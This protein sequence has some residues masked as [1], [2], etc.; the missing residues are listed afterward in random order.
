[1]SKHF[2][3]WKIDQPQLLPPSVQ[4]FVP[5]GHLSRFIVA[6]V[7]ESLDL[8]AIIGSYTSGLGQPP[9]DPRMM[10]ALLLNGYASGVYSSRRIA[11]AAIERADFMMIVAL[12]P[13]DFRTI[14]DFRKRHLTALAGLF[15]QVLKLAE[16]AGLV[17]LGHVALDGTKIKANASKHKAMSYERMK[18]REAELQA[19]VDRWL[20]AAEAA[21]AE[22]DELYGTKRGDELPDWV[23][24]KQKRLAKIRA[25]KAALEAEAK[26]IAEAERRIEAEKEQQRRAEGRK[27]TGKKSAP[28]SEEPDPKAQRNF[29]DPDSRILKTKDGFIQGYNAQ[30]A[31]DGEAQIIVAHGLTPS[32]S[33]HGQLVP[34]I[35]GIEANL[36]R[37]PKEASADSGYL[38]E[39]NLASLDQRGITPYIATGRAKHPADAVRRVGGPLTQAMRR[40]LKRAG[41]RSRYRLRKQIVEPVFGQI[42]QAREFRQFLLRGVA[43][44][45]AEWAM[46]CTAHNLTKLAKAA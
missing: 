40:K 29:T 9:F 11:K 46:I 22:E 28:P 7:R 2:R 43:K 21:D 30:A 33:D 13:P 3:P 17:K 39:A 4:D 31:V 37:K 23:A 41:W 35:D 15:V 32:M 19:E 16:T 8:K 10:V 36:G 34:L 25:A 5:E 14:S 38:S 26:A 42:K 12:D 6:L 20:A 27:K 44:V 1:M 18:R 24:D 45:S